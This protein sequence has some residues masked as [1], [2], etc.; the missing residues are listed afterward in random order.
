MIRNPARATAASRTARA[1]A[2]AET[3]RLYP[4]DPKFG[5][6]GVNYEP[7]PATA[8]ED[9]ILE[10]GRVLYKTDEAIPMTF[11]EARTAIVTSAKTVGPLTILYQSFGKRYDPKNKKDTDRIE[12]GILKEMAKMAPSSWANSKA[13][14]IKFLPTDGGGKVFW[15]SA[16]FK[17]VELF[18]AL[19]DRDVENGNQSFRFSFAG[20]PTSPR[21]F[22]ASVHVDPD[23]TPAAVGLQ[24]RI[25]LQR[26][27]RI[28]AIWAVDRGNVGA[29]H[30]MEFTGLV[31]VVASLLGHPLSN[32]QAQ[33][34]EQVLAWVIIGGNSFP[35]EFA[36]R[37]PHCTSAP[38]RHPDV[39]FHPQM[40]CP[41]MKC[42]NCGM[43]GHQS[44]N[45]P[46]P[47]QQE[48]GDRDS[49]DDSTPS[50]PGTGTLH[51]GT[52]REA[53]V[54][55][56]NPGANEAL[57]PRQEP[58]AG[59]SVVV[60]SMHPT[61]AAPS[62]QRETAAITTPEGP[63]PPTEVIRTQ[64]DGRAPHDKRSASA[65][66]TESGSERSL[67]QQRDHSTVRADPTTE[68][69]MEPPSPQ[70]SSA[71][72]GP[73]AVL[74]STRSSPRKQIR[75]TT[76]LQDS[77]ADSTDSEDT[78]HT[79]LVVGTSQAPEASQSSQGAISVVT[80]Y[81]TQEEDQL[82]ATQAERRDQN[83]PAPHHTLAQPFPPRS[84]PAEQPSP[85]RP[86][87]PSAL[88]AHPA[89]RVAGTSFRTG[90]H[91]VAGQLPQK[92]LRTTAGQLQFGS[93]SNSQ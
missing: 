26:S 7:I 41:N 52:R 44:R 14:R 90:D 85:P 60:R 33:D 68:A 21:V 37:P 69:A 59:P 88:G 29:G 92:M 11:I 45:C 39:A 2:V 15:V 93:P 71:Q 20:P 64:E 36:H 53:A 75:L 30:T 47:R 83:P 58:V 40:A 42:F 17:D 25:G 73:G 10:A 49:Q 62:Q 1:H 89:L 5:V 84:A 22:V 78:Q 3:Q 32:P 67:T 74:R 81:S 63:P 12:R 13:P 51:L 16:Q 79:S 87:G 65:A 55:P 66:F 57:S 6:P 28:H 18:T 46:R 50:G 38:C 76:G 86:A 34:W 80:I 9:G 19:R 72:P 23:C 56:A 48:E 77:Q 24:L 54:S 61:S 70:A 35:V 4:V 91:Q 8:I 43:Q 27:C 82:E 31:I